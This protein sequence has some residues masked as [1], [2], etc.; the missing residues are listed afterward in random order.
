MA[1]SPSLFSRR[2]SG[3]SGRRRVRPISPPVRWGQSVAPP[4][5]PFF[6][7]QTSPG[8]AGAAS[9]QAGDLITENHEVEF[10][11]VTSS[12]VT[13]PAAMTFRSTRR[14]PMTG[15]GD[16]GSGFVPPPPVLMP[17]TDCL[18]RASSR[19]SG[20]RKRNDLHLFR[21]SPTRASAQ[22]QES[23]PPAVTQ[24]GNGSQLAPP[25]G[26]PVTSYDDVITYTYR[27]GAGGRINRQPLTPADSVVA[28]AAS[29]S[30][31]SPPQQPP[32]S[33]ETSPVCTGSSGTSPEGATG[34]PMT[35]SPSDQQRHPVSPA[36]PIEDQRP[37]RWHVRQ[38]YA[39]R[40]Y[41]RV[42]L[43]EHQGE[44]RFADFGIR[45]ALRV[46]D[47]TLR[48]SIKGRKSVQWYA[49]TKR[50]PNRSLDRRAVKKQVF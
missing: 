43:A 2:P 22:Q 39:D 23:H 16:E 4:P 48:R 1:S 46:P 32:N 17:A 33:Q 34:R 11:T 12:V 20:R 35:V 8:G 31:K 45:S 47:N 6:T 49:D 13:A 38:P 26:F 50:K 42:P 5:T 19:R 28:A 41:H 37:E 40:R 44:E 15:Q 36:S 7:P 14:Y 27:F 10:A 24:H 25:V 18:A 3:R 30:P 29:L 9:V 21:V